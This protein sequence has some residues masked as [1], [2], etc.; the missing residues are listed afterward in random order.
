M[1]Y[2]WF[3]CFLHLNCSLCLP[4]Q[5]APCLRAPACMGGGGEGGLL[6]AWRE[7]KEVSMCEEKELREGLLF[8]YLF[9]C[10]VIVVGGGFICLFVII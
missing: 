10:C 4:R 3:L 2:A 5:R 6:S 8:I 7:T 1:I 9:I